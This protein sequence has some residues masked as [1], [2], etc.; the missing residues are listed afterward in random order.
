MKKIAMF[1]FGLFVFSGL[2]GSQVLAQAPASPEVKKDKAP[3]AVQSGFGKM[4]INGLLQFW[5][6]FD[7]SA[8]PDD[9]FRLRRSEI[10]LSGEITPMAL[11]AVMID[12]AQVREDD[13][14][15]VNIDGT[16]VIKSVGRK[17]VLQDFFATYKLHPTTLFDL[18]QYK[19]PFGMEGLMSSAELDLI[20][21]AMLTSQLKWADYRD[22]GATYKGDFKIE[23][24]KIQPAV[25]VYN[26]EGQNKL[27]ANNPPAYVARLVVKPYED[28]LHL[29]GAYYDGKVGSSEAENSHAGAE[30]KFTLDPVKVYGEYARGKSGGKNGETYYL[31]L[32]YDLATL[33]SLPFQLVGRYDWYDPDRNTSDDAKDETSVGLN[34]FIEKYKSKLS[35]NYVFRG[36]EG[37]STDNDIVRALAQ[38][39]F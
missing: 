15:T 23:S 31:T 11:W 10:K 17:S 21:R 25:G 9:T 4:K 3:D 38:V 28:Y 12:P 27:D 20:E 14:T 16:N 6:Q 1:V 7:D 37:A 2:L 35:V 32:A 24:A 26:G 5:Y 18:G 36:E 13:T 39:S 19:V 34:Y 22:I 33:I 8:T 29:G 30:F